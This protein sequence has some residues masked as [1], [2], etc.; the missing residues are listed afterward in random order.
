MRDETTAACWGA[1]RAARSCTGRVEALE[2]ASAT[3]RTWTRAV[4]DLIPLR[5][6]TA[7]P[8]KGAAAPRER[9]EWG[10]T[11][12]ANEDALQISIH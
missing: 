8:L 3:L 5:L 9:H 1:G 4:T 7:S 12:G 6:P 2:R 11:E 10:R